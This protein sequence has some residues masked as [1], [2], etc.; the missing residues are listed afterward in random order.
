M[1][2]RSL[3]WLLGV[4]VLFTLLLFLWFQF[5]T[6]QSTTTHGKALR[7]IIHITHPK[8]ASVDTSLNDTATTTIHDDNSDDDLLVAAVEAAVSHQHTEHSD[9]IDTQLLPTTASATAATTPFVG[10]GWNDT[11][12]QQH[13]HS[14]VL[15]VFGSA[16]KLAETESL[17]ASTWLQHA[18]ADILMCERTATGFTLYRFANNEILI[19]THSTEERSFYEALKTVFGHYRDEQ[20]RT[21]VLLEWYTY[22]NLD[23][24]S[25][26]LSQ[27]HRERHERIYMGELA[28]LYEKHNYRTCAPGAIVL[29]RN[30]CI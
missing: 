14:A 2:Q 7:K 1:A 29:G 20:V 10:I 30:G 22:L 6:T 25:G 13:Q 19:Q 17:F 18:H 5:Q 16:R 12:A 21:F 26:F 4:Q 11:V 8:H 9:N 28:R 27:L 15:I 23:R 24:F 3:L